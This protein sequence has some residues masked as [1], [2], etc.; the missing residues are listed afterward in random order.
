MTAAAKAVTAPPGFQHRPELAGAATSRDL[1]SAPRHRWF[2][3]PH[4]YS[5][6]L[7]NTIL[8]HWQFPPEGILAD[9]F[10]GSGT[11]LLAARERGGLSALGF[12]LSPLA[13]TVTNAKVAPYRERPLARALGSILEATP[14]APPPV[15]ERLSGTSGGRFTAKL[16]TKRG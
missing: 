12:D 5:Y 8:D 4:S 10:A 13:V 15:P 3:F 14:I 16:A 1:K 2:Y 11:T 7:V 6:R 9:N